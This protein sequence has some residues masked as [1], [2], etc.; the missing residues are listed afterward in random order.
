MLVVPL[1][2][3]T[4]RDGGDETV[5]GLDSLGGDGLVA[6]VGVGGVTN[7]LGVATVFG[8]VCGRFDVSSSGSLLGA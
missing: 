1:A 8:G 7:V 5:K 6:K 3:D 2:G 4:E